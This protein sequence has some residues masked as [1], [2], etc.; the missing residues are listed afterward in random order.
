MPIFA[1]VDESMCLDPKSVESL[2]TEK[3]RAVM[4]VGIGGNTGKLKEISQL[5]RSYKL[6]LIL[7]AAHM[8]GSFVKLTANSQKEHKITHVGQESDV[9]IFSF[10][11]VKNLP[12]ADSGMICFKD[13]D[14]DAMVRKT[15]WLG[16][17]KDTYSRTSEGGYKWKYS[18]PHLGF[19]YHGNSVMAAM[20][21][22]QLKYLDEDNNRRN[23][24]AEFYDEQLESY[25][26]I[27]SIGISSYCHK[28]SR[29]LYQILVKTPASISSDESHLRDELIMEF[30]RAKIY[31]G[32][33]YVDNTEYPMYKAIRGVCP[34]ARLYSKQLLT[35]PIHLNLD[36]D[37]L[38]R[39][40]EVVADFYRRR[41]G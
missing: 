12:T 15:S 25:D 16:I 30:N 18:V 14:K 9:V 19:K 10:Q 17:D 7:D 1:D 22:V 37:D 40:T 4:F 39:V 21:L 29:H 31:P 20:G 6:K 13:V 2:I 27:E 41:I 32:V 5:C 38:F 23:E 34:K 33:H 36:Q 28:S 8:A 3:T 26:C 35:L 24:I 11:A